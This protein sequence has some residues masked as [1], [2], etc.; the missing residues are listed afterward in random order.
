M[1]PRSTSIIYYWGGEWTEVPGRQRDLTLAL[2][3]HSH[4]FYLEDGP[5]PFGRVAVH[6]VAPRL[7]VIR[8][9]TRV[10]AAASKRRVAS[11]STPWVEWNLHRILPRHSTRVLWTSQADLPVDLYIKHD[12]LVYDSIDPC[13]SP[14]TKEQV[15]HRAAERRIAAAADLTFATAQALQTQL[16]KIGVHAALL[17]NAASIHEFGPASARPSWWDRVRGPVALYLGGLNNRVDFELLNRLP[18]SCPDTHFVYTSRPT[19][20]CMGHVQSLSRHPNVTVTGMLPNSEAL[21]VLQ[22][23]SIGLIPFLTNAVGDAINPNKLYLYAL[24]GL[25]IVATPTK[26]LT[27]FGEWVHLTRGLSSEASVL[28][29][30]VRKSEDPSYRERMRGFGRLNSWS[31]RADLAWNELTGLLDSRSK[32]CDIRSVV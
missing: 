6:E 15:R 14:F 20:D 5:V 13:L 30:A 3:R 19:P 4:V 1:K 9:L 2:R 27:R 8:G 18:T 7:T 17:P 12:L 29:E 21:Y 24:F 32:Q 26:E 23:A 25:P 16:H 28:R 31:S 11:L 22:N 10:I